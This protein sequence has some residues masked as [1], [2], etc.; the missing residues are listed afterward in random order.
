VQSETTLNA[1]AQ[2]DREIIESRVRRIFE[3]GLE[4]HPRAMLDFVAEDIVYHVGGSWMAF[5]C[6]GPVRGK[7]NVARAFMSMATQ[8]ENMESTLHT[9]VIDGEQVAVRRTARIRHRGTNRVAN[10]NV[11]HFL[12]FR[13]G[14]IVSMSEVADTIVLACLDEV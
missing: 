14:L 6:A 1:L 2:V 12:R 3:E 9:V 7:A 10:V 11:A 13:D 5:P 4:N 8:Y